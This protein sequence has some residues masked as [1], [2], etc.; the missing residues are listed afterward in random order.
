MFDIKKH[1]NLLVVSGSRSYGIH[2]DSSDVDVKGFALPPK[3]YIYGSGYSFEQDDSTTGIAKFKDL[4]GGDELRAI[5]ETKL[6][7]VVYSLHKFVSLAAGCN[8]SMLDVLFCRDEEVRHSDEIG[9]LLRENR[10]LFLSS[11]VKHTFSGYANQQ[12]SR[13]KRH[14]RWLF[15]DVPESLPKR[16]DFGLFAGID[17]SELDAA[18]AILEK[19][20]DEWS[21]DLSYLDKSDRVVVM[22]GV[23]RTLSEIG[24]T[25]DDQWKSAARKNGF[26]EKIMVILGKEREYRSKVSD[27]KKF[28]QWK[29]DRNTERAAMEAEFGYDLKHAAHLYRLLLMGE[30]ILTTGKVN[31]WREDRD[32]ILAIRNGAWSYDQLI[33]WAEN[34]NKNI[35]E[36]YKAGNL[37]VPNKVCVKS[38]S[39]LVMKVVESK[40]L[41]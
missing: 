38:I 13:I 16:E 26:D 41:Y 30:E 18:M 31:V 10:D 9:E 17:K 20:L 4:F 39:D 19:T 2:T 32:Q 21:L 14:R 23:S 35:S 11:K 15:G 27:W 25:A 6:E 3:E 28:Q 29:R 1:T 8:P 5:E 24:I 34:Q 36:I 40:Y 12:L 33:E 22:D 7:G 37:A